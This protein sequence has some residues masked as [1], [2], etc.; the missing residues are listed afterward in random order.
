MLPK[1]KS[2][3]AIELEYIVHVLEVCDGHRNNAAKIL[4]I[5]SRSLRMK[6]DEA[7]AYGY[8]VKLPAKYTLERYRKSKE[9]NYKK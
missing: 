5:S 2:L 4:Q 3:H 1:L 9:H 6:I 8:S 7:E